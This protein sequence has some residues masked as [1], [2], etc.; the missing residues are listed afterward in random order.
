MVIVEKLIEMLP[1]YAKEVA[2]PL[3][4]IESVK[5]VDTGSGQG[6]ASYGKS[7]GATML[8]I[9]EPLKEL[10]GIDVSKLLTDLVNRG[11]THTTVV[12]PE[13]DS[14][15]VEP[16]ASHVE[17]NRVTDFPNEKAIAPSLEMG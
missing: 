1:Q 3:R 14:K 5:I 4:N 10:T 17:D 6:V 12:I 8:N 16:M 11:N 13:K 2:G 9:Q 7:I 15:V